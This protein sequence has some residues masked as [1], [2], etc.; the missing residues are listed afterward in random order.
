MRAYEDVLENGHGL[1]G[2][3][4]LVGA[5]DTEAAALGGAQLVDGL[6]AEE[7]MASVG[8]HISRDDAEQSRLARAIGPDYA[9][10]AAGLECQG[11]AIGHHDLAESLADVVQLDQ[12]ATFVGPSALSIRTLNER[13]G[14]R[15][16]VHARERL[17][18]RWGQGLVGDRTPVSG[19]DGLRVL[20]TTYIAYGKS[21]NLPGL[22]RFHCT[23]TG[24]MIAT[25]GAGPLAKSSDPDIPV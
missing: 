13:S 17:R 22:P 5:P 4:Y 25:P 23:P 8:C 1:E 12:H 20:S 14:P 10:C 11:D 3:W 24:F 16:P 6:A 9:Q 21:V 18:W 2:A 7:D 19:T 15:P